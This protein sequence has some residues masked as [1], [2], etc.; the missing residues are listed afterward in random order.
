MYV[1][2]NIPQMM[3]LV[4]L[5]RL[6]NPHYEGWSVVGKLGGWTTV[7]LPFNKQTSYALFKSLGATDGKTQRVW[8][9][10]HGVYRS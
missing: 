8:H 2:L 1:T 3:R 7:H 9:F 5:S 10:V 4:H 6:R